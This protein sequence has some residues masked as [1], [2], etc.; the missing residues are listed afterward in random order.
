MLAAVAEIVF[1]QKHAHHSPPVYEAW[2]DHT[3]F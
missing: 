3:G 2:V 1:Y